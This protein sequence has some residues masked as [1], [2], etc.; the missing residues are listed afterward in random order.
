M[1]PGDCK[2]LKEGSMETKDQVRAHHAPSGAENDTALHRSE[3]NTMDRACRAH[4]RNEA[5]QDVDVF[6]GARSETQS[7]EA[8]EKLRASC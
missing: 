5:T 3:G 2:D 6:V 8:A 1:L 7:R 4:G